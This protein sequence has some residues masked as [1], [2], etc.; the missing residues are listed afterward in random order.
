MITISRLKNLINIA[1]CLTMLSVSYLYPNDLDILKISTH[2]LLLYCV[3][4]IAGNSW[5]MVTHHVS[6]I[7]VGLAMNYSYSTQNNAVTST[8]V[9]SLI[10]T[11]ISTIFLD[12]IYLGYRHFLVK[13]GFLITFTYFRVIGLPWLFIFNSETC[14][15]CTGRENYVCDSKTLSHMMWSIGI[16]VLMLLNCMWFSKLIMKILKKNNPNSRIKG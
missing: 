15:F 12:L 9:R 5:D 1:M 3:L 6:T 11:E 16:L 10:L 7:M 4:D 2:P 14:Y 13:L 8:V